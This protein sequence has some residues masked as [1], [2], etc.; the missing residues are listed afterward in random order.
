MAGGQQLL[1]D[2]SGMS[3][4]GGAGGGGGGRGGGQGGARETAGGGGS[5]GGGGEG[6]EIG[7]EED[8][9][10]LGDTADDE[11]TWCMMWMLYVKSVCRIAHDERYA[12]VAGNN[13]QTSARH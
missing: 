4:G 5:G 10:A 3:T 8:G 2:V 1:V 12:L 9:F 13:F 11:Q 6:M 7:D